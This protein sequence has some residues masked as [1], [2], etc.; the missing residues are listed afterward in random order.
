MRYFVRALLLTSSFPFM[1]LAFAQDKP[2]VVI[3]SGPDVADGSFVSFAQGTPT[4][5]LSPQGPG[6][7][8][9][10]IWVSSSPTGLLIEGA[11]DGPKPM[12]PT[13]PEEML[14]KDHVEV[15][16]A[17]EPEVRLPSIGWVGRSGP[18][19]LDDEDDCNQESDVKKIPACKNWFKEQ[20]AYRAQ[21]KRLFARQWLL[22]GSPDGDGD[23]YSL[24]ETETYANSAMRKIESTL[25]SSQYS[26]TALTPVAKDSVRMIVLSSG[27]NRPTYGF[28]I[29]IPYSAFPPVPSLEIGNLWLMVDVFSPAQN[30]KKMGTFSTTAPHRRWGDP[31]TFN[32]AQIE[33]PLQV[34]LSPCAY[35]LSRKDAMGTEQPSYVY[36]IPIAATRNDPVILDQIV[37]LANGIAPSYEEAGVSPWAEKQPF[38]SARTDD[39][40]FICG[41]KLAYVKGRISV[42]TDDVTHI[43]DP[44]GFNTRKLA[45]GWTL[46]KSGPRVGHNEFGWGGTCGSCPYAELGVYAISPEGK[47]ETAITFDHRVGDEIAAEDIDFS[48]DWGH[49]TDYTKPLN[50]DDDGELVWSAET[51]CLKGHAYEA[52]GKKKNI[53][54][55]DPPILKELRDM[56]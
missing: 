45:D 46:V 31:S 39:G 54:P 25:V 47:V 37:Y 53:V 8:D 52:C 9:G 48:T 14:S 1:V 2:I 20:L 4:F 18:E 55:P 28:Q 42:R 6:A 27:K 10:S 40:G 7:R 44:E 3:H 5:K 19:N 51:F 26:P 34:K 24:H 17:A 12:W 35:P 32:H 38:F 50:P 30:G 15:W 22:A 41:P 43:I 23:Y 56:D 16:L 29:I 36:P 21:F 33:H 11:I 49:V 13:T